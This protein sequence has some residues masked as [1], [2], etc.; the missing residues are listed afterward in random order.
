MAASISYPDRLAALAAAF[1]RRRAL[2]RLI[3]PNAIGQALARRVQR[4]T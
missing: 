2:L 3:L 4:R 1:R